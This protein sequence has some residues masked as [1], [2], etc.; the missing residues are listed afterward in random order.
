MIFL[1]DYPKLGRG[2]LLKRNLIIVENCELVVAWDGSSKGTQ[3][4]T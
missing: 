4:R 2:A 1:P 3:K